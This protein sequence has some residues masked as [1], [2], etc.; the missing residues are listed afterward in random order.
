M[1]RS[2]YSRGAQRDGYIIG[3][4]VSGPYTS[5]GK[6]GQELYDVAFDPEKG[7]GAWRPITARPN[8]FIEIDKAIGGNNR[9][10]YLKTILTSQTAQDI[11]FE[12][13]SDDGFALWLNRKKIGGNNA[14]RPCTPGSDEVK[15]HLNKGS[16]TVLLKVTQ[17]GGEWAV[18]VRL[19]PSTGI[20]VGGE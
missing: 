5:D 18:V 9:V 3:W 13:G 20:T 6:G 10:A 2:Q 11:T 15:A 4:L 7:G 1:Y 16:N 14:V 8:N 19:N 17:G 12:V